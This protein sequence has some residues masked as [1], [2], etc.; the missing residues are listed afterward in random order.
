MHMN[1]SD[2][3]EEHD[4]GTARFRR[5]FYGEGIKDGDVSAAVERISAQRWQWTI[6]VRGLPGWERGSEPTKGAAMNRAL[7]QAM[8]A[9]EQWERSFR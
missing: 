8:N 9:R 1:L 6:H 2:W 7:V 5:Q 4:N 3:V